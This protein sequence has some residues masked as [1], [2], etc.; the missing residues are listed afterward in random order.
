MHISLMAS[1][2]QT[3]PVKSLRT[4]GDSCLRLATQNC[5]LRISSSASPGSGLEMQG[6]RPGPDHTSVNLQRPAQLQLWPSS[7][8][9]SFGSQSSIPRAFCGL[10]VRESHFQGGDLPG[11]SPPPSASQ[12]RAQ[13]EAVM[14][15]SS[16]ITLIDKRGLADAPPPNLLDRVVGSLSTFL[17][18]QSF[19]KHGKGGHCQPSLP[20]RKAQLSPQ[21]SLADCVPGD[22]WHSVLQRE[23]YFASLPLQISR[24]LSTPVVFMQQFKSSGAAEGSAR[25]GCR[26]TLDGRALGL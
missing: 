3:G 19:Q 6:P 11:M 17:P 4:L 16:V 2:W 12:S 26:C 13:W 1:K 5:G 8:D 18:R 9:S 25:H 14:G 23:A 22:S 20:R 24:R 7:S 15:P 21:P 10:H